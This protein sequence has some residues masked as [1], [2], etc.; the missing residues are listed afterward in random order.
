MMNK[1]LLIENEDVGKHYKELVEKS[2]ENIE[3]IWVK[4]KSEAIESVKREEFKVVVYD[5]RL[6]N[7]ELGTEIMLEI[8]KVKPMLIG[9]MLSAYATP[10]D[11]AKAAKCDI[12]Y[13]Y[14]NKRD[15][16]VLPLKIV[17]ALKYYDVHRAMQEEPQ[18]QYLGKIRGIFSLFHPL[19]LYITKKDLIDNNYVFED[20]W[21][22][23]YIINAGE[24]QCVKKS[25][26]ISTSVKVVN[27]WEERLD[28][29]F[30]LDKIKDLVSAK[31]SS[32]ALMTLQETTEEYT[33]AVEEVVKTIKMPEIP[34]SVEEDYLTTTM[35]QG[36]QVYQ[37]YAIIVAQEC[38][39]CNA[40]QYFHLEVYV[41]TNRRKLRK[42]NTYRFKEQEIIE[43][44]PRL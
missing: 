42:V 32:S 43:V 14:V 20:E 21:E 25:I 16:N 37:Q 34:Q 35:L 22:S 38:R 4:N 40:W 24:E 1:I 2:I 26:E 18:K 13:E 5:Q 31:F 19:K 7:N 10:D 27:G 15:I 9:V 17:D 33:K 36:G 6:D 12:M 30:E 3:V 39:A 8:R 23:L 28:G 44:S 41:P 11:T 29:G